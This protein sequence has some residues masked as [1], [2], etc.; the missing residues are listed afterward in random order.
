MNKPKMPTNREEILGWLKGWKWTMQQ[1]G[2][3]I[4]SNYNLNRRSKESLLKLYLQLKGGA[5]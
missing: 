1:Y 4:G 5:K 3:P 2:H